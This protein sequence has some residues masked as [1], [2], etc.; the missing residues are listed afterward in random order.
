MQPLSR[1]LTV[2]LTGATLLAPQAYAVTPEQS[3]PPL[4]P[5][6]INATVMETSSITAGSTTYLKVST[7][8]FGDRLHVVRDGEARFIKDISPAENPSARGFARLG[9][10]L[11]FFERDGLHGSEPWITDGTAEGTYLLKDVL[12]GPASSEIIYDY[13]WLPPDRRIAIEFGGEVFFWPNRNPPAY[14]FGARME[15]L[16]APVR[17]QAPA[18]YHPP[19]QLPF[20]TASFLSP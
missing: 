2:V 3:A 9:E 4:L 11:F 7:V 18:T 10:K 14:R 1:I 6:E 12:P 5:A 8:E 13:S 15:P 19:A 16:K 20:L 17:L